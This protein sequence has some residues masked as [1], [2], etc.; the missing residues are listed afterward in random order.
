MKGRFGQYAVL[1]F[2]ILLI[3]SCSFQRADLHELSKSTSG[4]VV[5]VDYLALP[6]GSGVYSFGRLGVFDTGETR[7]TVQNNGN[8]T[9]TIVSLALSEGDTSQFQIN[10]SSMSFTISPGESTHFSITFLPTE[11]GDKRATVSIGLKEDRTYTFTVE[12]HG[13]ASRMV[14]T[15]DSTE[16]PNGVGTYNFGTH[17]IGSFTDSTFVIQNEG[18]FDLRITGLLLSNGN[19]AQFTLESDTLISIVRPGQSTAFNARYKPTKQGDVSTTLI[20]IC[21]DPENTE[22]TFILAGNGSASGAIPPDIKLYLGTAPVPEGTVGYDFGYIQTDKTSSPMTFVITNEGGAGAL[23]LSIHDIV[24]VDGDVDDFSVDTFETSD[25]VK[26]G[27]STT[28]NVLFE[29]MSA[30][31]KQAVLKIVNDDPDTESYTFTVTG[32]GSTQPQPDILV[33]VEDTGEAVVSGSGVYDFGVVWTGVTK[34]E[35][36]TIENTGNA[37]LT[38]S[39]PVTISG[40]GFT[41][42]FSPPITIGPGKSSEFDIVFDPSVQ[43]AVPYSETVSISSNDLDENPYTFI[44]QGTG[45][46]TATADIA[47]L[48]NS[49]YIPNKS[50]SYYFGPVVENTSKTVTFTIKN[51]GSAG[52]NVNSITS[53]DPQFVFSGSVPITVPVGMTK[54][55]DIT[56]TPQNTKNQR[57]RITLVNDDPDTNPFIFTVTGTGIQ[58]EEPD[59]AL[60]ADGKKITKYYMDFDDTVIGDSSRPVVFTIENR[61]QADLEISSIILTKGEKDFKIDLQH[62]FLTVS[63]GESTTFDA[64]FI[65]EKKGRRKGTLEIRSNDPDNDKLAISLQGIGLTG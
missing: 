25:Y 3:A 57:A 47:V 46:S 20:L 10:D 19:V 42:N 60:W 34:A 22:Y 59:I 39:S 65:P 62:T 24:F 33:G 13:A 12:G 50:G 7:F 1:L 45:N 29:P 5:Y 52:L 36:F 40:S 54:T 16:I 64:I 63:P 58:T 49:V 53:D 61:G 14:V 18:D 26:E 2:I 35:A 55:F 43:G 31:S 37:D 38:V 44:V 15:Q 17:G 51:N 28:F 30:G 41:S 27:E 11:S 9:A 48:Q 8:I 23:D 6:D 32:T 4:L 21:N 56:F